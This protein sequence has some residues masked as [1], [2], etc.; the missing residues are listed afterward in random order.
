MKTIF[1][2]A[3]VGE[4]T[5]PVAMCTPAEA[6]NFS[7]G[8]GADAAGGAVYRGL[9]LELDEAFAQLAMTWEAWQLSR[10]N[11]EAFAAYLESLS[12]CNT[13]HQ[14]L[15]KFPQY[16][17]FRK[18]FPSSPT[19]HGVGVCVS[20]GSDCDGRL[21]GEGM[22]EHGVRGGVGVGLRSRRPVP[23]A[24]PIRRGLA[25]GQ[26]GG[27][28]RVV[29]VRAV[30]HTPMRPEVQ[31]LWVALATVILVPA[32]GVILHILFR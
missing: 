26:P 20:H 25:F 27:A 3:G 29:R 21:G 7:E 28:G 9:C 1:P 16:E 2:P 30:T 4:E 6:P 17:P 31:V 24:A 32:V 18:D 14:I 8:L 10:P 15:K 12:E 22:D 11:D 23:G 13:I 19:S 5:P